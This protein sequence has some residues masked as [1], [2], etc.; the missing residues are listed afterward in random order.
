MMYEQSEHLHKL[1]RLARRSKASRSSESIHKLRNSGDL[2]LYDQTFIE[3]PS[4]NST[5]V[6]PN[7]LINT[8]APEEFSFSNRENEDTS[9]YS[10]GEIDENVEVG[11]TGGR[12]QDFI[13]FDELLEPKPFGEFE[14]LMLPFVYSSDKTGFEMTSEYPIIIGEVIADRYKIDCIIATTRTSTVLECFDV[15]QNRPV[16]VKVIDNNKA[17]YDQGLDEVKVNKGL[18]VSQCIAEMLDFF[19]YKEHLFLVFELLGDNLYVVSTQHRPLLSRHAKS[20]V[21]QVLQGLHRVHAAG[22]IHADI[23]PENVVTRRKLRPTGTQSLDVKLVDFGSSCFK[24]DEPCFYLQS[25]AYRAPEVIVG[26]YYDS[27]IDIWSTGCVL[28]ELLTGDVL[29]NGASPAEVLYLVEGVLCA[30]PLEGRYLSR[31]Y[32]E[33]GR[34]NSAADFIDT[35]VVSLQEQIKD[36]ELLSLLRKMLAVDPK[37]R[38]SAGEV[39]EWL[40]DVPS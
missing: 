36:E 39:L 3:V 27:K 32:D 1:E 29:F 4:H 24:D 6:F 25:L 38:P 9:L 16:C 35:P 30:K 10:F 20:I 23:K 19:Y 31:Y 8:R 33:D 7:Q 11:E 22:V 5:C 26:A 12:A 18:G 34:L 2:R 14:V 21:K 15:N 28:A 40:T 13:C 37:E 17:A